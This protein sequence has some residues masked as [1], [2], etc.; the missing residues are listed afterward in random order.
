MECGTRENLIADYCQSHMVDIIPLKRISYVETMCKTLQNMEGKTGG[1][2]GLKI[3][4]THKLMKR[5]KSCGG[6][7]NG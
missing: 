6:I 7:T 5:R 1:L 2:K 4:S 3:R